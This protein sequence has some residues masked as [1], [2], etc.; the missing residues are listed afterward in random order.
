MRRFLTAL[1]IELYA[2]QGV[3]EVLVEPDMV[4]TAVAREAAARLGITLVMHE[5]PGAAPVAAAAAPWYEADPGPAP[6]AASLDDPAVLAYWRA[7]FPILKDTIHVGNCSQSP[8]SARVRQALEAYLANWLT[9]G[10]DWEYWVNEVN[11]ARIEFARL[12]NADPSEV[13]VSTSVSE[14]V[15][16]V[17][18]ALDYSG[19]RRKVLCTEA[20]FPTV[21]HVWLAHQKLGAK[22]EFV[23]V[24]GGEVQLADYERYLDADTLITSITHVYYQNGFKQDLGAI[25]KL[26]HE[27]GAL[28]LVDAY[29][30]LG[31]CPIDVK[32]LDVD[33]LTS[34]NLKYLLG[35]PGIAFLYVKKELVPAMKPAVT[36]WF[37]QEKPFAFKVHYLD[38]ASTARR[39]DTGTP[40]VMAAF[41]ARAGMEMIREVGLEQIGRRIDMLSQYTLAGAQRRGL[42]VM[43]PLDIRCKGATTAIRVSDSHAVEVA[44]KQHG[45]IASA[46]G[47]AIRVAPHFFTLPAEIDRVL[48]TL[49]DLLRRGGRA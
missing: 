15:A 46:R 9:I 2:A 18:S 12:I 35:I 42:D 25:T 28:V 23:P 47:E 32:A 19:H 29:Q 39:F 45:I 1:D 34:G 24:R 22:V 41:A 13:A 38:Y 36:G 4:L 8:Q 17:A 21:G 33:F 44:L 37:G 30:S 43:S 3:R 20:E 16:G 48:D 40:P 26:A 5:A 11:K 6:A 14:A 10:M 49:A 7:Q 27:R 31:T